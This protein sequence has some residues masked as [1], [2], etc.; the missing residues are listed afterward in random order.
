MGK[1]TTNPPSVQRLT[2]RWLTLALLA[3]LPALIS[4]RLVHRAP[5]RNAKPAVEIPPA[6]PPDTSGPRIVLHVPER[7]DGMRFP[8]TVEAEDPSGVATVSVALDGN[9]VATRAEPP[10]R[11]QV[12]APHLPI[13]VKAL[14]VDRLGNSASADALVDQVPVCVCP[15]IYDPVCGVDGH[16][17]PN[18]CSA[19]CARVEVAYAGECRPEGCEGNKE[20]G[21]GRFCELPPGRCDDLQVRGRCQEQ[22][23]VCTREYAPV[24]GCDGNTYSND[25]QR[26]AAGVTLRG[27][28]PCEQPPACGGIA[29]FACPPGQA[30]DLRDARCQTADLAGNCVPVPEACPEIYAPVCG[31]DGQTYGNDCERLRAGATLQHAG[32]CRTRCEP[33]PNLA[34][35]ERDSDCIVVEGTGCCPCSS[36][37]TQAAIHRSHE[38]AVDDWQQRCCADTACLA[39]YLCREGLSARCLNGACMLQNASRNP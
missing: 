27:R 25:C 24:C 28:G 7:V 19:R 37:G 23:Q 4:A 1:R 2:L 32:P 18:P 22:P 15:E 3:L 26:R 31:C 13:R 21:E 33:L 11:F 30:C 35:C 16:T 34:R 12:T 5:L 14:A 20:C 29:G 36:G 8:V 9:V 38:K 10:Y 6:P 39:V 17:Y